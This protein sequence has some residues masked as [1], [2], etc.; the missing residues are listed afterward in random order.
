SSVLWFIWALAIYFCVA[1]AGQVANRKLIFV[2]AL[3]LSL[4]T[5]LG[6]IDFEHYAHENVLEFLPVFLF[7]VWYSEPL[8]NSRRLRHP[9]AFPISL[10]VFTAGFLVLYRG[11]LPDHVDGAATFLMAGLGVVVGLSTSIFLSRFDFLK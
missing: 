7:G 8:I 2:A 11:H 9:V 10:M 6:F 1:R 5:Y 3:L 4:S